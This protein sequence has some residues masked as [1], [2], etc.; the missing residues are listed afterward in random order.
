MN[1]IGVGWYF[2]SCPRFGSV[3]GHTRWYGTPSKSLSVAIQPPIGTNSEKAALKQPSS[4]PSGPP[5][6]P[7]LVHAPP[8]SETLEQ[9]SKWP[10]SSEKATL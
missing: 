7:L 9:Y 4:S 3:P 1:V 6:S 5:A 10:I 8:S 2:A